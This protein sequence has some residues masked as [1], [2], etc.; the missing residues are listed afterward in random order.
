VK[1]KQY[2][3]VKKGKKGKEGRARSNELKI[4]K[5]ERKKR[6]GNKA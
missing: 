2:K 6:I 5:R 3:W 4:Q 1:Q